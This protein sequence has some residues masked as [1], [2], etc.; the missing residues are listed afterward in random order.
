MGNMNIAVHR[1]SIIQTPT[2]QKPTSTNVIRHMACARK[3]ESIIWLL[4]QFVYA[5]SSM[6]SAASTGCKV[7]VIPTTDR[8]L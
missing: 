1:K 2:L 3:H 6:A 5:V 8:L 4:I 7:H